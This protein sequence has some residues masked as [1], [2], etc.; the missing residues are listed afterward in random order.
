MKRIAGILMGTILMLCP[1]ISSA[2]L[3]D[4]RR[5]LATEDVRVIY[6]AG[7]QATAVRIADLSPV[8]FR[9]LEGATGLAVDFRPT[10]IPA[11]N[12]SDFRRMGGHD[13]VV[14]FAL[15][16]RG[17]V[18]LDLSWFDAQP[19][20]FRPVLKH[21]FVHLLLHRH[22]ASGNLPRWLDEG[23]AQQLSDGLSEY[24]PG[25]SQMV[26]GEAFAADRVFPLSALEMRFPGDA[27]GRQLAYEQ[28]RS[29]VGYMVQR[30]G[31]EFLKA[32]VVRMADGVSVAKAFRSVNGIT[33]SDF[34]AD[35]RQRQT[36]PLSWM[37]LIAG[38]VYGLL[39]FLAAL[40]TLIG[41]IRHR[42]RRWAY[43]ASE[44][45]DDLEDG[46]R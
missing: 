15:P 5:E 26:L 27:F 18:V 4:Q 20:F 8:L 32:L 31:A 44:D 23:I 21:E 37:G 34:E 39:F 40:A 33:L 22:I 13:A 11:S 2:A 3:P 17:Q 38:H 12:R 16:Q 9:E 29:I 41:Y 14:G 24:L 46:W 35:W 10:V 6:D 43:Y 45:D 28:S 19:A 1:M 36:A 25:R 42:R 30:Y 7:R